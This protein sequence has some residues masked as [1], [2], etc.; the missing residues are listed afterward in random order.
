MARPKKDASA[1]AGANSDG[2]VGE[3][4][5]S[6][7]ELVK[8]AMEVIGDKA[9][10]DDL[11]AHILEAFGRNLNKQSIAT[12]K[13]QIRAEARRNKRGRAKGPEGY[14]LE[15]LRLVQ[16]L[17]HRIGAKRARDIIDLFDK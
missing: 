2:A 11:Q 8:R 6:Q 17:I 12:L 5:P 3:K 14:T 9:S 15:D 13:S 1:T 7:R 4:P 10:N 16:G